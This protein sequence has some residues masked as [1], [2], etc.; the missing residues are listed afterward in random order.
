MTMSKRNGNRAKFNREHK[1]RMRRRKRGRE[2]RKTL[3]SKTTGREVLIPTEDRNRVVSSH[4]RQLTGDSNAYSDQGG[5]A[6]EIV[7]YKS[8]SGGTK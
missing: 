2:L 5:R 8:H 7:V 4:L 1:K 3:G 6:F